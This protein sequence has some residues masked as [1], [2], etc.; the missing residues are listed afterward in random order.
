M[1][2]MYWLLEE[3]SVKCL[4]SVS[5]MCFGGKY[6]SVGGFVMYMSSSDRY[7]CLLEGVSRVCTSVGFRFGG[8]YKKWWRAGL[9]YVE[10]MLCYGEGGVPHI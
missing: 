3:G 1:C 8:K 2:G 9:C 4:A 5:H 6:K 10:Q 7:V